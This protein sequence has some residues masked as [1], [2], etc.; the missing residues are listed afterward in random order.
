VKQVTAVASRQP[1]TVVV[2]ATPGPVLLPWSGAV[3]AILTT[4]M[5]GEQV[6]NAV[7]DVLWGHTNPSARLPLTFPNVENEYNLTAKQW[8]GTGGRSN[9]TVQF[10]ERGLFGC[11]SSS[12]TNSDTVVLWL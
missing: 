1:N 3:R 4:F 2:V 10:S 9:P 7:A 11:A 8:P 5:C 6:G 12:P